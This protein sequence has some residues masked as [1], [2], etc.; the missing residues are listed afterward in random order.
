MVFGG[1]KGYKGLIA[2]VER[3]IANLKAL[4]TKHPEYNKKLQALLP[5]IDGLK[6]KDRTDYRNQLNC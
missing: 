5:K 1:G 2:E 3:D 4:G 6:P